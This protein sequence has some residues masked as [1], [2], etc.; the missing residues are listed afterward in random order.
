MFCFEASIDMLVHLSLTDIEH[1]LRSFYTVKVILTDDLKIINPK[2][3]LKY[4]FK[5]Y[6]N[7]CSFV[8]YYKSF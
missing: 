6:L 2:D 5:T 8:E 4:L 3:L 1:L 7:L